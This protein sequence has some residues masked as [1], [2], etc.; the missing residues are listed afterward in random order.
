MKR[1]PDQIASGLCVTG[2]WAASM[3]T[4]SVG[5]AGAADAQVVVKS[6]GLS[7]RQFASLQ[8]WEDARGGNLLTR[9][10][11]SVTPGAGKFDAGEMVRGSGC[12]GVYRPEDGART[13]GSTMTVDD[14]SG[15]CPAGTVLTGGASGATA[16]F[17]RVV[18]A[19]GTIEKGEVYN[20]GPLTGKLVIAGS[21]TDA[22]HHLWLAAAAGHEHNGTP[23]SGARVVVRN[24]TGAAIT[25]ADRHVVIEKLEVVNTGVYPEPHGLY[26]VAPAGGRYHRLIVQAPNGAGVYYPAEVTTDLLVHGS[27]YGIWASYGA[28]AAVYNAT[29]VKLVRHGVLNQGGVGPTLVNVAVYGSP[30]AYS[31]TAGWGAGSTNNAGPAGTVVPGPNA[32]GLTASD[33]EDYAAGDYRPS[34]GSRL[35]DAGVDLSRM[36]TDDLAGARRT[37]GWDIGAYA[38][39]PDVTPPVRS[40]GAPTGT[41][42]AGTTSAVLALSTDEMATCRYGT[43]AGTTY[44]ALPST[45]ATTGSTSH[46]QM[47]SGLTAGATRTYYVRCEDRAGNANPDDYAI[48]FSVANPAPSLGSLAPSGSVAGSGSFTLTVRGGGFVPKS[49][50]QWNGSTRP[51]TYVGATLLQAA[52]GAGDVAEVGA[53]QVVVV[54]PAPGGGTSNPLTFG[55]TASASWSPQN[56]P[57]NT[58][59]RLATVPTPRYWCD[60]WTDCTFTKVTTNPTQRPF[61]GFTYGNGRIFY[62]GGGHGA[63]PG[64]DVEIFDVTT[65]TWRQQY[66]PEGLPEICL[67][68]PK[69]D[70]ACVIMSGGA[71]GRNPTPLGRPTVEHVYQEVAYDPIEDRFIAV[72]DSGV[73]AYREPDEWVRLA[74]TSPPGGNVL[75]KLLIWEPTLDVLLYFTLG[76]E[77]PRY[78]LFDLSTN[79]WTPS[80]GSFPAMAQFSRGMYSGYDSYRH[81]HLVVHWRRDGTWMWWFDAVL[82]TWTQITDVPDALRNVEC[83]AYDPVNRAWLFAQGTENGTIGLWL[84]DDLD[85]WTALQPAGT[86]PTFVPGVSARWNALHYDPVNA[87]FYLINVKYG[88]SGGWSGLSEGKVETW[89]YRYRRSS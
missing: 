46:S 43:A 87:V 31:S 29:L 35:L 58:W 23:G 45:F 12:A 70:P 15:A 72:L 52:V 73:W 27:R 5:Q 30:I 11:W 7:G 66:P 33:F 53:A 84:L 75:N 83:L 55:I 59:L 51:T 81:K 77:R 82:G 17:G 19:E 71:G 41:L 80:V 20:D 88:S 89:T 37:A 86:P 67:I 79:T 68:D 36:F 85:Q 13:N 56:L 78:H 47:V 16:I 63:H 9:Q 3:L 54:N 74:T 62:F 4:V 10:I 25:V 2:L 60:H 44:A 69:A 48:S 76:N 6:I 61:S 39:P 22:T 42:A 26:N 21:T 34:V 38:A 8:A 18:S 50:V 28:R 40:S 14:A 64:N 24:D 32:V 65:S 57:D 1:W 49:V